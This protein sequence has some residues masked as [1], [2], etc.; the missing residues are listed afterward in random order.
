M[1]SPSGDWGD[2]GYSTVCEQDVGDWSLWLNHPLEPTDDPGLGI[3][4]LPLYTHEGQSVSSLP[5]QGPPCCRLTATLRNQTSQMQC[6]VKSYLL[7]YHSS[8]WGNNIEQRVQFRIRKTWS[9]TDLG[10]NPASLL[11][12]YCSLSERAHSTQKAWG[13]DTL[14]SCSL[15]GLLLPLPPS[16]RGWEVLLFSEHFQ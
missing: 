13:Q 14:A 3:T 12:S 1:L 5:H 7:R 11:T 15:P 10:P 8:G 4:Q 9:Q 6:S 2:P 16:R